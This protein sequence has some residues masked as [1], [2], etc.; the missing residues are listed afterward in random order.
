MAVGVGVQVAEPVPLSVLPTEPEV[1]IVGVRLVV[2][3]KVGKLL[4]V[5]LNVT[6]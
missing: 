4:G 3:V 6:H 5:P 2:L 1:V